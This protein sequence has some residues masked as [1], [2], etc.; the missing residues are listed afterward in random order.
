MARCYYCGI[1]NLERDSHCIGCSYPLLCQQL[2]LIGKE[3]GAIWRTTQQIQMGPTL[4]SKIAGDDAIYASDPQFEL[5][6]DPAQGLWFLRH[7]P[8]A[9]NN[10][11]YNGI[12]L[13]SRP[14]PLSTG[15]M[16][17]LAKG[18]LEMGVVLEDEI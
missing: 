9:R 13:Q 3:T 11:W 4:L 5:Y 1:V 18:K 10:T 17:S 16:I 7:N 8:A 15:G 2:T 6:P 14:V 12:R